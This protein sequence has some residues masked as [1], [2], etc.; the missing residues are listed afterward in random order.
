MKRRAIYLMSLIACCL[1]AGP[2]RLPSESAQTNAPQDGVAQGVVPPPSSGEDAP[3]PAGRPEAG[4]AA[5]QAIPTPETVRLTAALEGVVKLL[6]A[7]VEEAVL[8][9][10]ITHSPEA[11]GVG[12]DEIIYLTDVGASGAVISAMMD[13][14]QQLGSAPEASSEPAPPEP[15]PPAGTVAAV[16]A[17]G[18]APGN[19]PVPGAADATAPPVPAEAPATVTVEYF[20]HYLAPYGVWVDLPGYGMCWQPAVTVSCP[21]WMP[22]GDRGRWVYADCGWYWYSDYTWGWAVFHY[23]RWFH[24]TRWGWCWAPG[25]VWGPSWV[26][27]R[28][29]DA[30]CGWAPLPPYSG[31]GFYL[32]VGISWGIPGWCYTYVPSHRICAPAPRECAVPYHQ[33]REIHHRSEVRNHYT[34]GRNHTIEN[35][36]IPPEE[37]T[38]QPAT[39]IRRIKLEPRHE[40]A[41]EHDRRERLDAERNTLTVYQPQFKRTGF[42]KPTRADGVE[43]AAAPPTGRQSFDPGRGGSGPSKDIRSGK[44]FQR[45]SGP[46]PIE[47]NPSHLGKRSD[48]PAPERFRGDRARPAPAPSQIVPEPKPAPPAR[49]VRPGE[50]RGAVESPTP[51][52]TQRSSPSTP[53]PL[54]RENATVPGKQESPA[55]LTDRHET[56]R[57][58]MPPA[59]TRS[60]GN[61]R[62]PFETQAGPREQ[63]ERPSRPAPATATRSETAS[64]LAPR[65]PDAAPSVRTE[66]RTGLARPGQRAFETPANRPTPSTPYA[67]SPPANRP[68]SAP[69]WRQG[70]GVASPPAP[71]APTPERR[72]PS[73]AHGGPSVRNPVSPFASGPPSA[74]AAPTQSSAGSRN[75][76]PPA[77]PS[78]NTPSSARPEAASTAP[79]PAPSAPPGRTGHSRGH[80]QR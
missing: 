66:T 56:R 20:H 14:D 80:P 24:H 43:R 19:S 4:P 52:R 27:W 65:T 69:A 26:S 67:W 29:A 79:S 33:A 11:F 49:E 6:K 78:Y 62:S 35:R 32:S 70:S 18:A 45:A 72:P 23:G 61:P 46:A 55:A 13:R 34:V 17:T 30:Y 16:P 15:W 47:S 3:P 73:A 7:G 36:G 50:S 37:L 44:D 54:R 58:G 25:T 59:I 10:H 64:A 31:S 57:L 42:G 51:A 38:R 53:D 2:G 68:P 21:G 75:D 28:Y 74:A 71:V 9:K 40:L 60:S 63:Q 77:S 1:M 76:G 39:D 8:L 41:G 48:A 5:G 12:S 22:Y